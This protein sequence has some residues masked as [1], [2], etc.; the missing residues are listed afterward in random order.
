MKLLTALA[1]FFAYSTKNTGYD[2][3]DVIHAKSYN[4]F[5][6]DENLYLNKPVLDD[7]DDTMSP[8][9]LDEKGFVDYQMFFNS[10][11]SSS[12]THRYL[13]SAKV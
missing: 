3:D 11:E 4:Q 7:Q 10:D 13:R 8:M 9:T 2:I 12:Q 6:D 5:D 1:C